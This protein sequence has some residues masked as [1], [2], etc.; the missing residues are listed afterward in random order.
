MSGVFEVVGRNVLE[1]RDKKLLTVVSVKIHSVTADTLLYGMWY[2]IFRILY[3]YMYT[4]I[5]AH[6]P[7]L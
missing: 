4:Y 7:V 1:M 2:V 6:S 3:I 5:P